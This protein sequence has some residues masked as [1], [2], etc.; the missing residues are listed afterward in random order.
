M[1]TLVSVPP[2]VLR[3]P[4][5]GLGVMRVSPSRVLSSYRQAAQQSRAQCA[6][7]GER[8]CGGGR[9]GWETRSVEANPG[10]LTVLRSKSSVELFGRKRN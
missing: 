4:C 10:G 2:P 5:R 7:E 9:E 8:E 6:S 3:L 1:S